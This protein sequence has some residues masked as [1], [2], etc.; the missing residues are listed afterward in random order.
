MAATWNRNAYAVLRR[1]QLRHIQLCL[2][3]ECCGR[4]NSGSV[5]ARSP[6]FNTEGLEQCVAVPAAETAYD[7]GAWLRL[8]TAS[9]FEPGLPHVQVVW[10]ASL[11]C[12][13]TPIGNAPLATSASNEWARVAVPSAVAPATTRSAVFEIL[14]GPSGDSG[15]A[16][17]MEIDSA[18]FGASGSV[19]VELQSFAV[20]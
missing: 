2:I 5:S 16:V 1:R 10:Y 7:Y 6:L 8:T 15:T 4:A 11:D 13:G 12:S 9:G 20:E 3:D 19:P 14:A 18:F 17:G